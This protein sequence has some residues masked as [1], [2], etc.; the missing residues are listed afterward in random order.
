VQLLWYRNLR[1]YQDYYESGSHPGLFD[2]HLGMTRL[3][4]EENI[5]GDPRPTTTTTSSCAW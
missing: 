4:F 3:L 1:L 5:H 2:G